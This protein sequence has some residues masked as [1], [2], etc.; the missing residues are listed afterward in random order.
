MHDFSSPPTAQARYFPGFGAARR[1]LIESPP[2]WKGS[3]VA[4]DHL[5]GEFVVPH[6]PTPAAFAVSSTQ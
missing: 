2:R 1:L 5:H 6:V 3:I 4:A